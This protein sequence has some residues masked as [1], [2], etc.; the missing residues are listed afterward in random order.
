LSAIKSDNEIQIVYPFKNKL[1]KVAGI[2]L[3]DD[4]KDNFQTIEVLF[5]GNKKFVYVDSFK[6]LFLIIT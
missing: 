6:V 3:F 5:F 2:K 4:F 1:N